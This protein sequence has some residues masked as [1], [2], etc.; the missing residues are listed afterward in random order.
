MGIVEIIKKLQMILFFGGGVKRHCYGKDNRISIGKKFLCGKFDI[1]IYGN[2]N[3]LEIGDNCNF[4]RYNRVFIGGDNNKVSIGKDNV[5]D[6]NVILTVAEGTTLKIGDNCIFANGV[7][8]RTS[9]QHK[10]ISDEDETRTN[11]PQDIE[12]G[13]HVWLGNSAVIMKGV[14]IGDGT[15]IGINSLVTKDIPNNCVAVGSPA[16]VIKTNIHWEK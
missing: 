8:V 6:Q 12:I 2:N 4:K 9:D 14:Q 1:Y 5:F 10:I 11:L 15:V 7:R 3:Y 13:N 16:K